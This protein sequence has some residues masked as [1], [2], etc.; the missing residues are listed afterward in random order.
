MAPTRKIIQGGSFQK[1]SILNR[2][3]AKA[4]STGAKIEEF[5]EDKVIGDDIT[6]FLFE[7]EYWTI[8]IFSVEELS[9]AS[10]LRKINGGRKGNHG[11]VP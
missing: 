9:A 1:A 3:A 6:E 4:N 8:R 7:Y 5:G 11:R 10:D 2:V